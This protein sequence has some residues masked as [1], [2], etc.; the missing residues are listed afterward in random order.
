MKILS[1]LEWSKDSVLKGWL[2]RECIPE[3]RCRCENDSN[4]IELL[5]HD[6]CIIGRI[7]TVVCT[8]CNEVVNFNIVR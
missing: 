5:E 3:K 4:H 1:K 8:D 7:D 2:S 6:S